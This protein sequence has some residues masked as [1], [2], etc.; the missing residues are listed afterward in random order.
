MPIMIITTKTIIKG[1]LT[2]KKP[3]L[4]ATS[5]VLRTT[6]IT[7]SKPKIKLIIKLTCRLS[8]KFIFYFLDANLSEITSP[9]AGNKLYSLA[10][11]AKLIGK[12]NS[13]LLLPK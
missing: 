1:N 11:R 8:F 2:A 3:K 6:K 12:F 13:R 10:A 5:L 4:I 9:N 7:A